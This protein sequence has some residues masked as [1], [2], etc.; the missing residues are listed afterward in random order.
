MGSVQLP[1]TLLYVPDVFVSASPAQF[2]LTA[3]PLTRT[4][5][6]GTG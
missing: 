3:A 1:V 6:P 5:C 2:V 4:E